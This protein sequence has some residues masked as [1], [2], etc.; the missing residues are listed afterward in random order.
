MPHISIS[1]YT[2]RDEKTKQEIADKMAEALS[3]I[4]NM[5][6]K[7]I[8]VSIREIAKENWKAE[9]YD[10]IIEENNREVY[11]KPGYEM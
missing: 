2:G 10:R 11:K 1:M 3:E 8:S 4:M 7:N 5:E 6:K 9:V